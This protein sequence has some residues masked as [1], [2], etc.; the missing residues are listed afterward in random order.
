MNPT[1]NNI[2]YVAT[3]LFSVLFLV[4]GGIASCITI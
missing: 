3:V 4:M 2:I 1:E